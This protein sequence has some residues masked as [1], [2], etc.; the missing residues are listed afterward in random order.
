MNTTKGFG[1]MLVL[2]VVALLGIGGFVFLREKPSTQTETDPVTTN[3]VSSVHG[4]EQPST[5]P[6]T[7]EVPPQ[8]TETPP[9]SDIKPTPQPVAVK[10]QNTASKFLTLQFVNQYGVVY[11]TFD[12]NNSL[13]PGITL[14]DSL[15]EKVSG[16]FE[17][18]WRGTTYVLDKEIP[19]GTYTVSWKEGKAV[20]NSIDRLN[21]VERHYS[22]GKQKITVPQNGNWFV[23]IPVTQ[24]GISY[25]MVYSTDAIK[26]AIITFKMVNEAGTNIP[27]ERSTNIKS[28]V[29]VDSKGNKKGVGY[30]DIDEQICFVNFDQLYGWTSVSP[31]KYSIKINK[32]G[33]QSKNVDFVIPDASSWTDERV[34]KEK[35]AKIDLGKIVLKKI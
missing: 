22:S 6:T 26:T 21:S 29:I 33:Y 1:A 35:P 4:T 27:C 31:G 5:T 24:T 9:K 15:G 34:W 8:K 13:E 20:M 25:N 17:T 32:D 12:L 16:K 18:V 7:S 14:F 2:I 28:V 30:G 3:Q 10:T 19:V 11:S 23:S